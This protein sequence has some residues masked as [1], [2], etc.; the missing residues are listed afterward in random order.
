MHLL[1]GDA[2]GDAVDHVR[3]IH[4]SNTVQHLRVGIASLIVFCRGDCDSTNQRHR[5]RVQL[6]TCRFL[7]VSG[8][9]IADHC[10]DRCVD[11]TFRPV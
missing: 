7:S 1:D 8:V 5:A 9:F 2:I 6:L 11:E 3:D 10:H 4:H